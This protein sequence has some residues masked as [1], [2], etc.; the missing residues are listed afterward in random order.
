MPLDYE[1]ERGRVTLYH[2]SN[3]FFTTID[4][5]RTS[6]AK[7]FGRGFYL[8]DSRELAEKTAVERVARGGG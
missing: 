3:E 6:A 5:N 1:N 7:D 2:G 4:L 8:T